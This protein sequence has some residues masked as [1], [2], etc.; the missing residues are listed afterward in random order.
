MQKTKLIG[1]LAFTPLL[2]AACEADSAKNKEILQG[3]PWK[4]YEL[5]GQ[6]V[7][8]TGEEDSFTLN[9]NPADSSIYGKAVCNRYFSKYE[10]IGKD[11]LAVGEMG[12]TMMACPGM[13]FEFPY[14]QLFNG[15]VTYQVKDSVLTLLKGKKAVAVFHKYEQ[16]SVPDMHTAETSLDYTGTY[17]GV[18]PCADCPGIDITI[19]LLEDNKYTMVLNY[20]ERA[21]TFSSEGAYSIDKN[22]ITLSTEDGPEYYFVGEGYLKRLDKDKQPVTGELADMYI[23]K[24]AE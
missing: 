24:K 3:T 11:S 14:M 22:I 2:F 18:M 12:A 16:Q 20:Q 7:N 8:N 5:A 10:L 15:G 17:K 21:S 23:L 6:Q 9:F 1:A 4:L 19:N 13:E